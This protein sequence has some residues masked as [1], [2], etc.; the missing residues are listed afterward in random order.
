MLIIAFGCVVAVEDAVC[1][2][3][4]YDYLFL[5]IY[6]RHAQS[7]PSVLLQL[8]PVCLYYPF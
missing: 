8:A 6:S 3:N 5:S 4:Y 7:S 2:M 1:L